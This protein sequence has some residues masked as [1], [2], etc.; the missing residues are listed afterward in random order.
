MELE[1]EIARGGQQD[2]KLLIEESFM[3]ANSRKPVSLRV[4][5][6]RLAAPPLPFVLSCGEYI[7]CSFRS[8]RR[9]V[10]F[11]TIVLDLETFSRSEELEAYGLYKQG[12]V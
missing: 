5:F 2:R 11:K 10:F 6:W 4:V 3:H 8:I 7:G 1:K 9:G 12:V